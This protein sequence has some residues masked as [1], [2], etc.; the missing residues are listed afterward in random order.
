MQKESDETSESEIEDDE[1]FDVQVDLESNLQSVCRFPEELRS[2]HFIAIRLE[3]FW[4]KK[5]SFENNIA[6][7]TRRTGKNE[8]LT[9]RGGR[10]SY[11][12]WWLKILTQTAEGRAG[13]NFL[14]SQVV[15][16]FTT[17]RGKNFVL[18]HPPGEECYSYEVSLIDH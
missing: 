10:K 14:P 11:H 1:D 9:S 8:I 5:N 7:F 4:F 16:F 17:T 18:T 2:T 15:R 6:F 12:A 3:L 13:K